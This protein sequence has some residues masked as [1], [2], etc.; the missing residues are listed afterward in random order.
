MIIKWLKGELFDGLQRMI[1]RVIS[2][3]FVFAYQRSTRFTLFYI[4]NITSGYSIWSTCIY[5]VPHLQDLEDCVEK[6][7]VQK[8]RNCNLSWPRVIRPNLS[9]RNFSRI[10]KMYLYHH[11]ACMIKLQTHPKNRSEDA[12]QITFI[13]I[14]NLCTELVPCFEITLIFYVQRIFNTEPLPLS[15]NGCS[16]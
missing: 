2:I 4:W 13:E 7:A 10:T 12:I 14:Y 6:I 8:E 15:I 16:N 5:N 9:F 3:S 1:S 11:Y